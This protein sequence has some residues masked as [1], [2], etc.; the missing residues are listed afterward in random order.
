MAGRRRGRYPPEYKERIVELVR[1]GRS[2]GSLAREFEPSE[3]TIRNWVKQADLD[4]CLRSDGLTTE[5]RKEMQRLKRD[6]K[7]LRMER[8]IQEKRRPGCA[9]KNVERRAG[10]ASPA[11]DS[12]ARRAR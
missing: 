11:K 10:I 7:R 8:D 9:A 12:E 3:Q 5:A 1:A 2:P 6:V 4:E